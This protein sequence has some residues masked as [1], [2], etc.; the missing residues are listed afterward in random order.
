[1]PLIDTDGGLTVRD[2]ARRYRV[3][4]DK[5]RGW[6]RRGE[7]LAV[8]TAPNNLARPRWVVT[9]EALKQ[10]EAGRQTTPP[11]KPARR[12]KGQVAIDYYPD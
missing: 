2:I 3:G 1:M 6:I 4:P 8:N 9:P 5:V 10:F 7:L 11:P 12:R